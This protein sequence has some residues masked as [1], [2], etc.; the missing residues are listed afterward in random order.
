MIDLTLGLSSA[1][2][3]KMA[4]FMSPTPGARLIIDRQKEEEEVE[5]RQFE[6]N[7]GTDGRGS[8]ATRKMSNT[9]KK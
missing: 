3:H 1:V 6:S 4:K 2:L 7:K 8:D 9:S 5:R